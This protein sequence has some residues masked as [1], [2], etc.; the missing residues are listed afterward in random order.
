MW[1]II[2]LIVSLALILVFVTEFFWPLLKGKPLFG[3][4]RTINTASEK[5][6]EEIS[7]ED[8]MAKAKAKVEEIKNTQN[9]IN[10]NFKTAEQLKNDADNLLK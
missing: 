2:E 8:K 7:L 6:P 3:S 9:E 1:V 10:Q 5:T 4:F